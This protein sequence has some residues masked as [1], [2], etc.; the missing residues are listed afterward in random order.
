M[1]RRERVVD[2]VIPIVP[3]SGAGD[4]GIGIVGA[5]FALLIA[6]VLCAVLVCVAVV[7]T[8]F[9]PG[10]TVPTGPGCYPFCP[11]T[12]PTAPGVAR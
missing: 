9:G 4:S 3:S 12:Q 8:D 7:S 1:A 6:V 2:V 5:M 11:S 10:A